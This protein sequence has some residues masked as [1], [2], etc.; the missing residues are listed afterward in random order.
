MTPTALSGLDLLATAVVL[1][2]AGLQGAEQTSNCRSAASGVTKAKACY[3]GG[4]AQIYVN[5]VG[6]DPGGV[7]P[8]ADY[9]TVRNQIIAAF[10]N[11][12]NLATKAGTSS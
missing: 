3:A 12:A 9:E 8:A 5:L 1:V 4:T 2:D 7:V 10:Q 11:L 6:R